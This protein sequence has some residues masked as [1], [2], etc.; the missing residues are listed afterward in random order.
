MV[1]KHKWPD[2]TVTRELQNG[3]ETSPHSVGRYE[4]VDGLHYEDIFRMLMDRTDYLLNRIGELEAKVADLEQV[5][6]DGR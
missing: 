6:Q 1:S 3:R 4:I 2:E 5:K